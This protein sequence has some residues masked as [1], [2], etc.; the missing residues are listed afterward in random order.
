MA[1]VALLVL[2]AGCDDS[3]KTSIV[4]QITAYGDHPI[5]D[6]RIALCQF[7]QGSEVEETPITTPMECTLL[8]TVAVSSSEG[9]FAFEDVPPGLYLLLYDS[10]LGDFGAALQEWAGKNLRVGDTEW[11]LSTFL[12]NDQGDNQAEVHIFSELA[13]F[14][15]IRGMEA[16]GQYMAL[17]FMLG[18]SPFV[19]AHDVEKMMTEGQMSIAVAKAQ[20]EPPPLSFPA[21]Y[22]G[23]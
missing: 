5:A 19:L 9:R 17:H 13:N 3:S 14:M 12:G 11:L 22:F 20:K 1:I 8:E 2:T 10:G 15:V 18:D 7:S 21:L 23:R 4:G 6:R 16:T